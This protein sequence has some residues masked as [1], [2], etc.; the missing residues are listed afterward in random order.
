M[1]GPRRT[2]LVS[3]IVIRYEGG[4]LRNPLRGEFFE[5]YFSI[6]KSDFLVGEENSIDYNF[7]SFQYFFMKLVL[8][9]R[10]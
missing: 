7:L 4:Y 10:A 6:E 3:H 9:E 8:K 5:T 2:V 1:L